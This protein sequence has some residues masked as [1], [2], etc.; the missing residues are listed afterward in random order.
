MKTNTK[1]TVLLAGLAMSLAFATGCK[2]ESNS[3]VVLPQAKSMTAAERVEKATNIKAQVTAVAESLVQTR[4]D[5]ADANKTTVQIQ[6]A[7]DVETNAIMRQNLVSGLATN[8]DEIKLLEAKVKFEEKVLAYR[9]E[10]LDKTKNG[11]SDLDKE[12]IG[13][14]DIESQV[15][16]VEAVQKEERAALDE[17]NYR[18][19]VEGRKNQILV[20]EDIARNLKAK[21]DKLASLENFPID[22]PKAA[23]NINELK[24]EIER[25]EKSFEMANRQLALAISQEAN[26]AKARN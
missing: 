26:L 4:K 22:D 2:N 15:A 18:T 5:L 16:R 24:V 10:L 13:E 25:M 21:E 12:R 1:K 7:I 11:M 17:L 14:D 20:V 23:A 9:R 19:A 3:P 8:L 6:N